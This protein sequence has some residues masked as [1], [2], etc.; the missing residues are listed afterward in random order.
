MAIVVGTSIH[1]DMVTISKTRPNYAK[2]KVLVD[3]MTNLLDHVRM[4]IED[5]KLGAIRIVK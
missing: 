1:L 4:D 5:E 3:L 2:V